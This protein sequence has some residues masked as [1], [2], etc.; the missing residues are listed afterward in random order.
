MSH[1]PTSF[2]GDVVAAVKAAIEEAIP[3]AAAEVT[4]AGGHYSIEVTSAAF[5]EK[6][7]LERQRLVYSAIAH[8]MKGDMA[9]VHAVDSLKTKTP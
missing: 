3:D 4:G 9:P 2:Q 5:A 1:H 7:V 6:G 8:L